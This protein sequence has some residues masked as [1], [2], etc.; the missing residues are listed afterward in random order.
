[1]NGTQAPNGTGGGDRTIGQVV[2]PFTRQLFDQEEPAEAA[3]GSGERAIGRQNEG[4]GKW[5]FGQLVNSSIGK[6]GKLAEI[7][8][9]AHRTCSRLTTDQKGNPQY[10]Q[11][12]PG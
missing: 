4:V 3:S 1:M 8:E 6:S 9:K 7:R 11:D 12:C 5:S 2:D 10:L